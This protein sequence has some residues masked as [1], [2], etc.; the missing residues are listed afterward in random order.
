[1]IHYFTMTG[2]PGTYGS[3]WRATDPP[4]TSHPRHRLPCRIINTA[5]NGAALI[6]FED[7][8]KVVTSINNIRKI[9][10]ET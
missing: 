8:E 9:K 6:E 3:F 1:M 2:A 7:G 10:N 4:G 5:R